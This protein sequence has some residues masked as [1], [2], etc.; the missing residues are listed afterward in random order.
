MQLNRFTLAKGG[1]F[2]WFFHINDKNDYIMD[3]EDVFAMLNKLTP[4]PRRKYFPDHDPES[5]FFF[6]M[7]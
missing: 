4:S 2:T 3:V 7:K 1:Q 5:S 6:I